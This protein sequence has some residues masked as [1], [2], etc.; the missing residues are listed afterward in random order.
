MFFS[1]N[2]KIEGYKLQEHVEY[3]AMTDTGPMNGD[4]EETNKT[5]SYHWEIWGSL[6]QAPKSNVVQSLPVTI[7]DMPLQE[8]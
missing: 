1:G 6:S 8:N 2:D 3:T 5:T 7:K 4:Q